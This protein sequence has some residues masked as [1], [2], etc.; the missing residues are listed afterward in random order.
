MAIY[1]VNKAV[2]HKFVKLSMQFC[3]AK[4]NMLYLEHHEILKCSNYKFLRFNKNIAKIKYY[5]IHTI[6]K[7]YKSICLHS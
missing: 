7:Y 2:V 4:C 3:I 5:E 6:A 1:I